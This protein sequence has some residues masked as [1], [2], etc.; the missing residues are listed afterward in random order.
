MLIVQN[1]PVSVVVTVPSSNCSIVCTRWC[2]WWWWLTNFDKVE[3]K[4]LCKRFHQYRRKI[5]RSAM[6]LWSSHCKPMS[7]P[8]NCN[9]ALLCWCRGIRSSKHFDAPKCGSPWEVRSHSNVTECIREPLL[10]HL[11]LSRVY[12]MQPN[13]HWHPMSWYNANFKAG[14]SV[15]EEV[16]SPL[17]YCNHEP[18]L[19]HL[20]LS[21]LIPGLFLMYSF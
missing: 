15:W 17:K 1:L 9:F 4:S 19:S 7:S 12:A 8:C 21:L 16:K 13:I 5:T 20:T 3:V 2:W 11:T 6:H 18:L 10:G 14:G